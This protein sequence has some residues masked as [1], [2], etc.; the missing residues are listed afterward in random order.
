MLT[1]FFLSLK[2]I[3]SCWQRNDFF[4]DC[5]AVGMMRFVTFDS[6]KWK[7]FG[8]F[9]YHLLSI[10]SVVICVGIICLNNFFVAL[11]EYF[12]K[13]F[14]YLIE[15]LCWKI[16]IWRLSVYLIHFNGLFFE[17]VF[18]FWWFYFA[19]I[20]EFFDFLSAQFFLIYWLLLHIIYNYEFNT[21][22]R[23]LLASSGVV[24]I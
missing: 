12:N 5:G 22:I 18:V 17:I 3:I 24:V 10:L 13:T 4:L 14:W 11:I 19:T 1:E 6:N 8:S 23:R 7:V 15:F 9:F 2:Y 20:I 21:S 16:V